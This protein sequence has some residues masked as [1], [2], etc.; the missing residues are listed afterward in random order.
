MHRVCEYSKVVVPCT[1]FLV[2]CHT[3]IV[4]ALDSKFVSAVLHPGSHP[5]Q[6][7]CLISKTIS[8]QVPVN[9]W[10]CL[11]GAILQLSLCKI[12]TSF[13][14]HY[15]SINGNF[16]KHWNSMP[17]FKSLNIISSVLTIK[18]FLFPVYSL[19][20]RNHDKHQF[21]FQRNV[22]LIK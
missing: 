12:L 6:A 14:I 17:D 22:P 9:V 18:F 19:I 4:K 1:K 7:S 21:V 5:V 8:S 13:D 15:P 20:F 3:V 2:F 16:T 10:A 11:L